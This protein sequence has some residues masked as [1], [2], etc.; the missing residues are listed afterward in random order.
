M[1]LY[2]GTQNGQLKE[3]ITNYKSNRDGD[4][5]PI[6]LTDSYECAFMYGASTFRSYS[7]NKD[8]DILVLNEKAPEGFKKLYQ[9]HGC[10]IFKI[11]IEIPRQVENHPLGSHVFSYDKNITLNKDDCEYIEDCYEKLL[12]LEKDGKI[13]LNR[14]ENYTEE[15]KKQVKGKFLKLVKPI[16]QESKEK[17]PEDYKIF[18]SFYPEL[19]TCSS[20]NEKGDL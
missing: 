8:K 6:Y 19:E 10:Y 15:E 11:N 2:H 16:L 20:S 17:F 7:L 1:I 3:L 9:G 18:I 5:V 14:W 12:Q 13:I 4:N